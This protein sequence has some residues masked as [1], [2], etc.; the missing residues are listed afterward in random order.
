MAQ[1]D[2]R[3]VRVTFEDLEKVTLPETSAATVTPAGTATAGGRSYGN[4]NAAE[5]GAPAITEE[6]GSFL[7]QGWFYLGA[8]GLI[9]AL[10]GWAISE[11]WYG[12]QE[13]SGEHNISSL[14][15]SI[16]LIMLVVSGM[17][18]CFGLAESLV[19]RSM[20]KATKRFLIAL[21]LGALASVISSIAATI[22]YAFGNVFLSMINANAQY[23]PAHWVVRALAWAVFGVAGGLV[24]GLVGGSGKKAKFGVLGGVI[25]AGLGGFVFDP[26]GM[27]IEALHKTH[28]MQGGSVSR[29][30]GFALFGLAT[31]AAIG[32]VES[33]LKDR[34]IYVSAGP[35]AGKQFILY[36]PQTTI[37]SSQ[38][39][40][41]Y[42]FKDTSISPQHAVLEMRGN[43]VM[44]RATQPVYVSGVPTQARVLMSGD[45]IQIGRYQFRYNE[46]HRQ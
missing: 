11:P 42:L 46:R 24:Y 34:W 9:G 28:E 44:L 17:I 26:I 30:V 45:V 13:M 10:A 31:G 20:Q 37:G 2:E 16:V 38:Q 23:S 32:F 8:A 4:I 43:Q 7:L 5:P 29:A 35:L 1:N 21:P 39:S 25:G 14:V 40:D 27:G 18:S 12:A 33:A 6:K 41:I 19:E 36:K 15:L 3:V 22:F